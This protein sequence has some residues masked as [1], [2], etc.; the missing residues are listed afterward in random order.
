MRGS[1]V[2]VLLLGAASRGL[3][4]HGEGDEFTEVEAERVTRASQA[5]IARFEAK[6]NRSEGITEV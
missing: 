2:L 6:F 5:F 1:L 3:T 4:A